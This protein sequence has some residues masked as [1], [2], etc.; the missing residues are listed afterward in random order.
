MVA[1]RGSRHDYD[2][3]RDEGCV[4]WSYND[5]LP[6]FIKMEDVQIDTL[7]DSGET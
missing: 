2:S 6:Y 3:W 5:V 4:G 1:V 7:K